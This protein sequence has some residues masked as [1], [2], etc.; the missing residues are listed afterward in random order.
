MYFMCIICYLNKYICLFLLYFCILFVYV[1]FKRIISNIFILFKN[2]YIY[3]CI[4][5]SNLFKT[6]SKYI[7]I[8]IYEYHIFHFKC[9][10]ISCFIMF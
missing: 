7:Y 10:L 8:K 3:L 9:M 2:K 6:Y 5:I 4:F 1:Y